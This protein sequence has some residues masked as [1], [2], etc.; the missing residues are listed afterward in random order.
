[1]N[2]QEN[3]QIVQSQFFTGK[4]IF[5][6]I[7]SNSNIYLL[8]YWYLDLT[9]LINGNQVFGPSQVFGKFKLTFGIQIQR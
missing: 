1:M 7:Q 2:T 8:V 6:Y 5:I 4:L 9:S 3:L